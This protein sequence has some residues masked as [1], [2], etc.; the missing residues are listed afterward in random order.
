[1]GGCCNTVIFLARRAALSAF[2]K[3]DLNT[4]DATYPE[5]AHS[6]GWS[7]GRILNAEADRKKGKPHDSKVDGEA[8][9]RAAIY[10]YMRVRLREIQ[11]P[12]KKPVNVEPAIVAVRDLQMP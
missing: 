6:E 12:S 1:M 11:C 2:C 8:R 9:V 5:C 10:Q 4:S 3:S 7:I